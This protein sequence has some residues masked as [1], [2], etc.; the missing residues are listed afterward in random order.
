M[1]CIICDVCTV[2]FYLVNKFHAIKNSFLDSYSSA[3]QNLGRSFPVYCIIKLL[4]TVKWQLS[5][6]KFCRMGTCKQG[7]CHIPLISN[8]K[9]FANYAHK[10]VRDS[11][12]IFI[13]CILLRD[14]LCIIL[15]LKYIG[16]FT[17]H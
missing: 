13:N 17:I 9:S 3:I 4:V 6:S 7:K 1:Y 11:S 5:S 2:V 10:Q 16:A 15:F 8:F 12:T 14:N